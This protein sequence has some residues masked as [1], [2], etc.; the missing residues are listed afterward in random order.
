MLRIYSVFS[1]YL[2][3]DGLDS[4]GPHLQILL[5]V[6]NLFNPLVQSRHIY[7]AYIGKFVENSV[8]KILQFCFLG[9]V[10]TCIGLSFRKS[11]V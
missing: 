6:E 5:Q 1:L 11:E 2:A 10:C 7:A 8:L 9:I 3:T 4:G